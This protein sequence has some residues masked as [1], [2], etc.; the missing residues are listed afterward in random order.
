ML[1]DERR[2]QPRARSAE[3]WFLTE[4]PSQ[5]STMKEIESWTNPVLAGGRK[6]SFAQIPPP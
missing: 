2:R 5:S 6:R 1:E 3:P 4:Q